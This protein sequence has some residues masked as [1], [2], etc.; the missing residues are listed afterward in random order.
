MVEQTEEVNFAIPLE[1][2][3][4]NPHSATI[5]QDSSSLMKNILLQVWFYLLYVLIIVYCY[6]VV[7]CGAVIVKVIGL[8]FFFRWHFWEELKILKLANCMLYPRNIFVMSKN[9]KNLNKL[10]SRCHLIVRCWQLLFVWMQVKFPLQRGISVG[11][12]PQLKLVAPESIRDVFDVDDVKL[13]EWPEH[14][15][16]LLTPTFPY[17]LVNYTGESYFVYNLGDIGIRVLI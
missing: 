13:P 15:W 4:D 9:V 8:C 1:L 10:L 5:A 3:E 2:E 6:T 17:Y 16:V 7:S 11:S 14:M 12:A